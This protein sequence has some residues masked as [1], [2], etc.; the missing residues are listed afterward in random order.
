MLTALL[1]LKS[2]GLIHAD[3]KPENIML[4][5]PTRYP[6]RVKVID[7]GSASHVSKAVCSTY[8]Q[9]RYYRAPEILLGLPFCEAIDMWSLGCVMAELFLGW[10]LYPGSCEYDQVRY[11]SQTQSLPSEHLLNAATKTT[12]FFRRE[13]TE[14][15]YPFW[16]LKSPEEHEAE[17][18]IKSK[19]ARKYIFNNL[20]DLAQI[21]VP[22]D[23]DAADAHA[24][25]VD[26]REFIDLLKRMLTL[27][28]DRR[29]TPSEALNHAWITLGH[30]FEC[31]LQT[32]LVKQSVSAMEIC[33]RPKSSHTLYDLPT[34][35]QTPS[36]ANLALTFNN[37]NSLTT[38]MAA[39][40]A[41]AAA[42]AAHLMVPCSGAGA[43]QTA[44]LAYLPRVTPGG[45]PAAAYSAAAAAAVASN[46]LQHHPPRSQDLAHYQHLAC[47]TSPPKTS[48][49]AGAT[50]A[51]SSHY[52]VHRIDPNVPHLLTQVGATQHLVPVSLL[53]NHG[54]HMLVPN[55]RLNNPPIYL[56][57]KE[58][59]L[60]I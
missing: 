6:Y 50:Q 7:F 32:N 36:S 21:N 22:T 35:G 34:Q 17:Y 10:P 58:L 52:S 33:R 39:A 55:V 8:L 49:A 44:E 4:V 27:D 60:Y 31:N 40:G 16:R 25:K 11:I 48:T 5:N 45:A 43:V 46:R 59:E 15:N 1:K 26:R 37:M 42:A 47:M 18:N 23:L 3:L 28:Q 57:H 14:S 51:Q 9:S 29:I 24:D 53:D 19:E 2:L 54:R 38:H 56:L 30:F 20:D 13:N 12:R 41:A